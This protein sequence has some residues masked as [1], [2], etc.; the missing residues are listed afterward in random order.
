M[1]KKKKV[2]IPKSVLDLR[3][4]PKKFAKKN[5]IRLKGK[6]MSKG[7]RKYNAKRLK[8]EYSEFAISGLNKAVKIMAENPEHKKIGKVKDGVENI[9]TNPDVMNRV[10]KIY[11][12]HPDQYSNMIFM[13]YII[14]NTLVYYNRKDLPEEEKAVAETLD[15]ESLVTFCEK[16]LK[17]KIKRYKKAGLTKEQSFQLATVIPTSK[18]FASDRVWYRRLIQQMYDLAEKDHIEPETIIRAAMKVDKKK[19]ISKKDFLRGFFTEFILQKSTNK[20][21]KFTDTQ[22]ELHEN[23]INAAL[24]YLDNQKSKDLRDIL[25]TYIKR[26][27]KAE[28]YKSDGKR[29]IKFIDHATSNTP[30]ENIKKVVQ[31]LIEDDDQNEIYLG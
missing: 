6:G 23:L 19:N 3:M 28:A 8:K 18:L 20:N 26:R 29:V 2:K 15:T 30:Y 24:V 12:K 14:M 17:K 22:K 11:K 25:K 31:K 27:K 13:P 9:I 10:A 1:S 7:E 16:I 5:G 4:T 21:A